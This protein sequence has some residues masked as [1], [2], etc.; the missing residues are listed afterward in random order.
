[1]FAISLKLYNYDDSPQQAVPVHT[2]LVT[3]ANPKSSKSVKVIEP[4]TLK[5][6]ILN[7]KWLCI[8]ICALFCTWFC[9]WHV[10]C[11]IALCAHFYITVLCT[12]MCPLFQYLLADIRLIFGLVQ[13]ASFDQD[14]DVYQMYVKSLTRICPLT[15]YIC[16]WSD[17]KIWRVSGLYIIYFV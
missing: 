8:H 5:F 1:M 2:G 12:C 9:F 10:T 15:V 11:H 17:C 16:W 14:T 6:A 4:G 7:V 13:Y 3:V